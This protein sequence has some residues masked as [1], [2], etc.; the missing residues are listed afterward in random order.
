[1]IFA[2]AVYPN[3]SQLVC[4]FDEDAQW[5]RHVET[6]GCT[7]YRDAMRGNAI[8]Q[9]CVGLTPS[10]CAELLHHQ[11]FS[12][13]PAVFESNGELLTPRELRFTNGKQVVWL[14]FDKDDK[15]IAGGIAIEQKF[16]SICNSHMNA[17]GYHQVGDSKLE[18]LYSKFESES[19]R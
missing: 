1:M 2:G 3:L 8:P 14:N 4:L 12:D 17:H 15:C 10:Q 19:T 16:C 18:D 7:Y 13:T 11:P 6:T 9:D 5:H